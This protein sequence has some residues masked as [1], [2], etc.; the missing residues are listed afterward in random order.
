M[1]RLTLLPGVLLALAF[2][3]APLPRPDRAGEALKRM[4]GV[5]E[6][7]S[8][9][10][11]GVEVERKKEDV[12]AVVVEKDRL[13]VQGAT[14]REEYVVTLD[15]RGKPPR[16]DFHFR[17]RGTSPAPGIF[18]FEKD[19]LTIVVGETGKPPPTRFDGKPPT[20]F[21]L[22]KARAGS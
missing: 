5:W 1:R 9:Q 17:R 3:P 22:R 6:V 13:V 16:I 15:A 10:H 21:V 4:Q 12:T 8:L 11:G 14:R 20:R 18:Q 19:R 7:V 2:A